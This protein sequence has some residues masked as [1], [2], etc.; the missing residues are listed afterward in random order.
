MLG[1]SKSIHRGGREETL[2]IKT[3]VEENKYGRKASNVEDSA[4]L[5]GGID[6]PDVREIDT[7]PE[8]DPVEEWL[9]SVTFQKFDNDQIE[10]IGKYFPRA[11]KWE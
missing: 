3:W 5:I 1:E 8:P 2:S 11:G 4:G 9:K 7:V 6:C 10:E